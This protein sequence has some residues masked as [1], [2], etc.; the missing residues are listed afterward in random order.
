MQIRLKSLALGLGIAFLAGCGESN[1]TVLPLPNESTT[2]ALQATLTALPRPPDVSAEPTPLPAE[3]NLPPGSG[4]LLYNP[5]PP[6][7]VPASGGPAQAWQVS[8]GEDR[9]DLYGYP[10]SA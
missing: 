9:W 4:R 8:S 1:A 2:V 3:P 7:I 10:L 5:G 6:Q